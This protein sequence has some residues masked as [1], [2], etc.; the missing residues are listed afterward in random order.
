MKRVHASTV[1]DAGGS[2]DH[3]VIRCKAPD[4]DQIIATR[5]GLGTPLAPWRNG[6][7]NIDDTGRKPWTIERDGRLSIRCETCGT[8]N[9]LTEGSRLSKPEAD[10]QTAG[11]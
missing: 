9:R 4:C 8:R 1:R 5:N 2:F 11:R 6:P 10:T 3:E 7:E